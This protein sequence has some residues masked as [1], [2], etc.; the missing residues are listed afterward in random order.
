MG[1][2]YFYCVVEEFIVLRR[3]A[4]ESRRDEFDPRDG[5]KEMG[6]GNKIKCIHI[7]LLY[8]RRRVIYY[9]RGGGVMNF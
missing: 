8:V 9:A 5:R 7:S 4:Q 1:Y 2:C 6:N 3:R